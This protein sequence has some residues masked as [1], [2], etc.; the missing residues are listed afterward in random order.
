V[1]ETLALL[2]RYAIP[3][4][5]W[6]TIGICLWTP[7]QA[8]LAE[9][10]QAGQLAGDRELFEGVHYLSPELPRPFM[11]RLID[12]LRSRKGV[13]VQVNQPYAGYRWPGSGPATQ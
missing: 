2:D 9:A 3:L 11:E 13:K 6:V 10:R 12:D 4:D 1:R 8:V 5:T 7:H